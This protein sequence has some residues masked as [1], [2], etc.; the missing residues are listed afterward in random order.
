MSAAMKALTICQ[1][2]AHYIATGEKR[3]ENRCWPT[4]YRGPLVIHAGKNIARY[5]NDLALPRDHYVWGGFVAVADLVGC[6]HIDDIRNF[7]V[8]PEFCW[9]PEHRHT[10]GPWCFI[11]DNIR[12]LRKPIKKGGHQKLWD[13]EEPFLSRI[14]EQI[15]QE[16]VA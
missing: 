15:P 9:V 1:P 13:V 4:N 2:F 14:L 12:P 5:F 6:L 11:L 10:E 8:A 16:A 7:F 3:V